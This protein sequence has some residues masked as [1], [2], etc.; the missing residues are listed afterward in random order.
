MV[1]PSGIT[2]D[3]VEFA[4]L[5]AWKKIYV[6]RPDQLTEAFAR[7]LLTYAT[8]APP[9]F[10][11]RQAIEKIVKSARDKNYGVRSIIHSTLGSEVFR[12]K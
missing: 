9:R 5:K 11:D 12:T 10:S 4:D 7:Q 3:G 8:G 1:D 2:P 6:Q